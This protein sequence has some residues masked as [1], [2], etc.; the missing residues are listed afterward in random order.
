MTNRHCKLLNKICIHLASLFH[1]LEGKFMVQTRLSEV[2]E[3]G[4]HLLLFNLVSLYL[5]I[6]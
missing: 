3:V 5:V 1:F 4:P 6:T 2:R